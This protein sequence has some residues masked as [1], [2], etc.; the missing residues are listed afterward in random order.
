MVSVVFCVKGCLNV[1]GA[2]TLNIDQNLVGFI[3]LFFASLLIENRAFS[4]PWLSLSR[5]VRG[6]LYKSDFF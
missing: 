3:Y 2:I 6:S 4:S 1:A 5:S